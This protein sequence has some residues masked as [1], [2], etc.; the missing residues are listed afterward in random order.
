MTGTS[1]RHSFAACLFA[2]SLFGLQAFAADKKPLDHSV[3][4]GWRSLANAAFSRDGKYFAYVYRP[5]EG[6]ATGEI[7][8][9]S[10]GKTITIPRV[11][12]WQFTADSKFL[13]AT[14]VP[15][16]LE[17]RK[18]RR[19]KVKPEDQPKNNLIIV[20]LGTEK[21]TT[22]ERVAASQ[23]GRDGSDYLL[24]RLEPAKVD[25]TKKPEDKKPEEKKPEEKKPEEKSAAAKKDEVKKKADHKAGQTYLLRNLATGAETKI[26]NVASAAVSDDMKTVAL[27][28][29]TADGKADGVSLLDTKSG[30]ITPIVTGLGRYTRLTFNKPGSALAFSTDKDDYAA[31]KPAQSY[32][33]WNQGRVAKIEPPKNDFGFTT[34]EFGGFS[35][36][37]SGD[38]LRYPIAPKPPE[39]KEVPDDEKVS[40]DVWNYKD[41]LLQPQQLLQQKAERERTYEI[42]LNLRDG[43]QLLLE[44]PSFPN[45]SATDK[46]DGRYLVVSDS[47]PYEQLV[48]WDGDFDDVYV[49]DSQTGI[50]T[51]VA[52]KVRGGV[53]ASPKGK[54]IAIFDGFA[55]TLSLVNT[56]SKAVSDV[57]SK[58][59]TSLF[60]ELDDHPDATPDYGIAGWSGDDG[61]VYLQDRYD[62]WELDLNS[63][64]SKRITFGREKQEIYRPIR[65]DPENPGVFE[66]S[67]QWLS[68]LNDG[69]KNGGL[70]VL[71]DG[72]LTQKRY[73]PK[74]YT[75][76]MKPKNATNLA[77]RQMDVQEYPEYWLA[78]ANLGSATKVTDTNAQ[79]KEYNWLTDELVN[80]VS[81]DGTPLQGI[82]YKPE[83]FDYTKKYPM[84]TYFYERN[85]DTLNNYLT[86]APSA[87]TVNIP[88]FVS[89]GYLV[90]VPDIP[91]KVGYPGESAISA[92]LPGVS[93][94][95]GRGYVDPKRLGIQGQS[96]G[97]YQVAYMVTETDMF[98]AA[99]AGAPVSN[100]FSAYGGIRYGSGLVRQ[101]QY[102][103][104]QSRIGGTP[105]DSTL[106][107][108]E[109]SPI[110]HLPKVKT[111]LLIMANDKDGAVPYTQGIEL[112]TGLRRLGKPSWLLVY[113]DEDHNLVQRKNRKDLSIR[114]SQF[115]DHY[116]KG[117]PMPAWMEKGVPAVDKGRTMGTE[118]PVKKG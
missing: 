88:L 70:W 12:T 65:L 33:L 14:Q 102:E 64:K 79:Q 26:E 100:M 37:E 32:Y 76:L 44:T 86:P 114:L 90:F 61:K 83:N 30:K 81:N 91:Y 63:F 95:V 15:P 112:F 117:A 2:T 118:M 62:I 34:S 52:T 72:K 48:S 99:S 40:L 38:K 101:F 56:E 68:S 39:E 41:G 45:A 3:Y 53:S 18:A 98:A 69:N 9:V 36:S 85:S 4:D 60:D 58:F 46:G 21:V 74:S 67:N 47:R 22:I 103:R 54:W 43:K 66:T 110:F 113:N 28:L 11:S 19:D 111:P 105:W 96:W 59:S 1:V 17:S 42:Q 116:L 49:L 77:Y 23:L 13:V 55:K 7:R 35:F 94:V 10:D 82:L 16:F 92:I 87:S 84:I 5:Q 89:Q 73:G 108:I 25:A 51:K 31:K 6:D 80:W 8:R 106:K 104:Q 75:G 71:N 115:F 29:S 27:S 107:Y 50:R 97:G 24:Y 78:D 109:N 20:D 93:E 57:T